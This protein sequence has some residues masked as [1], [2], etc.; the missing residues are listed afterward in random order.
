MNPALVALAKRVEDDPF[1]L[2]ALLKVYADSEGL[3]DA[4]LAA[5][6]ACRIDDL[7]ALRLCRAPARTP[8]A[9]GPMWPASPNTSGWTRLV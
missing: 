3:D 7:T 5:V 1:F 8:R 9:S 4:R 6:L 2:A